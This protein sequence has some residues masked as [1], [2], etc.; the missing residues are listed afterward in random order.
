MIGK[1]CF[2]NLLVLATSEVK[3]RLI[4]HIGIY[5]WISSL[6]WSGAVPQSTFNVW[7]TILNC[8]LKHAGTHCSWCYLSPL[9]DL[10]HTSALV[11][12]CLWERESVHYIKYCSSEYLCLQYQQLI[13][14]VALKCHRL[15]NR[16]DNSYV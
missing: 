13:Y 3:K 10:Q 12:D 2:L 14:H 9:S 6:R 4:C 11:I 7:S 1:K 8:N 16:P 5:F 15:D